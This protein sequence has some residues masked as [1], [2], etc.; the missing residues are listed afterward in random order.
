MLKYAHAEATRPDKPSGLLHFQNSVTRLDCAILLN[1]P[2]ALSC[3]MCVLESLLQVMVNS[4]MEIKSFP[5]HFS[6]VS[7]AAASPRPRAAGAAR[8]P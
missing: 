5:T 1:A 8:F 3:A 6:T 7:C 4:S 2:S